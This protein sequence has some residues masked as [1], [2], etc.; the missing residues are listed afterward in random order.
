LGPLFKL[1][2]KLGVLNLTPIV[3]NEIPKNSWFK[4]CFWF[5]IVTFHLFHEQFLLLVNNIAISMDKNGLIGLNLDWVS[6]FGSGCMCAMHLWC[7]VLKRPILQ[8]RTQLKQL[9]AGNNKGDHCT[10]GLQFDWFGI[11]CMTID[12]FCYYLQ[13]RLIQTSQT[14]G[15]LCSDTTPLS[16]PFF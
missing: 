8:L 7:Y 4:F 12:N 15:Q 3:M 9:L 13:N 11:S 14:G 1:Q 16:I 5:C 6:S 2:R 10:V